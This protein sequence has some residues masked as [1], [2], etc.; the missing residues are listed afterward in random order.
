M[1]AVQS[2]ALTELFERTHFACEWP[3][4][5]VC[6]CDTCKAGERCEEGGAW[7]LTWRERCPNDGRIWGGLPGLI[8][9]KHWLVLCGLMTNPTIQWACCGRKTSDLYHQIASATPLTIGT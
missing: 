1:T 6:K 8:C 3:N 5:T 2:D 9:D 7:L 4:G